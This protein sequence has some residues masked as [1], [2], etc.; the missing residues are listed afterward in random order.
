MQYIHDFEIPINKYCENGQRNIYPEFSRCLICKA[1]TPMKKHGFYSRYAIVH[2]FCFRISIRRYWCRCCKQTVSVLP[3]LLLPYYQH[4]I[5]VIM[6]SLNNFFQKKK[7]RIVFYKQLVESHGKRFIKNIPRYI[8][9]F[10]DMDSQLIFN[11]D[12]KEKAIKLLEM[13]CSFPK[14]AFAKRFFN[15]FDTCFMAN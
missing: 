8:S 14:E 2:G 1:V 5:E 9:F 11:G 13:I 3:T 15:H 4:S 6:S 12:K 10:R 7:D